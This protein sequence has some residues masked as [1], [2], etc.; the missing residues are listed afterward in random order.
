MDGIFVPYRKKFGL[1]R[2]TVDST[3]RI[4]IERTN[5]LRYLLVGGGGLNSLYRITPRY[6]ISI[7]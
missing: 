3:D 4:C 5:G 7:I 1:K 6:R 2:S